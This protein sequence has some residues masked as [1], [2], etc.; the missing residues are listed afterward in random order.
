MKVSSQ[1]LSS[2]A[3]RTNAD[4]I[5]EVAQLFLHEGMPAIDLTYNEGRWW[6]RWCPD[7]L[8]CNDLDPRYG[9]YHYDFRKTPFPDNEFHLVAFDPPYVS[10]GGRKTSTIADMNDAYGMTTSAKSPQSNQVNINLG[11][12]EAFRICAPGGIILVK[13]K[14]YISSGKLWNGTY[15]TLHHVYTHFSFELL[16][17]YNHITESAG[18]QPAENLDGSERAQVHPRNNS[19]VLYVFRKA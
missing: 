18:P 12:D 17:I 11:L 2:F 6:R 7:N 10:T 4:L 15:H 19:S 9:D 3:W 8:V 1:L 14:D 5:A 16:A 13:C